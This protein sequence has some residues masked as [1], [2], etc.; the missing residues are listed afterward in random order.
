M[1]KIH[2]TTNAKQ[3]SVM[4]SIT[5]CEIF[6]RG[7]MAGSPCQGILAVQNRKPLA[8]RQVPEP[9]RGQIGSPLLFVS[10]N[11]SIDPND[12]SPEVSMRDKS[13]EEY[14][15]TGFPDIFP[16]IRFRRRKPRVVRFWASIR[17]RAAEIWGLRPEHI[18]PGQHFSITEIVHCKSK[19][20][21]GVKKALKTCKQLHW[22]NILKASGAKVIVVLGKTAHDAFSLDL[23]SPV[24]RLKGDFR[25]QWVF[26]LPHPN[27]R[28]VKKSVFTFYGNRELA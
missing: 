17:Q 7:P 4:C 10:S 18:R 23:P 16:K 15:E 2:K 22:D 28:G 14:F 19:K 8:R 1:K 13:L 11:P 6:M 5:R 21:H 3:Q 12:D 27:A 26:T 25:N 9:W 20:E 24:R